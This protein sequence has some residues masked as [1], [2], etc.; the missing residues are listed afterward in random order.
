MSLY[1]VWFVRSSLFYLLLTGLLGLLFTFNPAWLAYFRPTHIHLGMVGFF[2]SLVMGVA[3]WL[4][5]RPGGLKQYKLEMLTFYLLHSGL[6]LRLIT[7]PWWRYNPSDLLKVGNILSA[8]L[9]LGA[10]LTFTYA[11]N[12]RVVSAKHLLQIRQNLKSKD[13]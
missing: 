2:L 4:M 7:E 1:E 11:M 10:M 13:V 5:P 9:Q 8:L 12:Q 3:F 6:L